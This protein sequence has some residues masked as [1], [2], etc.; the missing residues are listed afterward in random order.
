MAAVVLVVAGVYACVCTSVWRSRYVISVSRTQALWWG[1]ACQELVWKVISRGLRSRVERRDR[2][3]ERKVIKDTLLSSWLLHWVV[4]L[5]SPDAQEDG[6]ELALGLSYLRTLLIH[7]PL[8]APWVAESTPSCLLHPAWVGCRAVILQ[9][10]F[11]VL[12]H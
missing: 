6:V 7:R 9:Y 11:V 10:I 12:G 1:F 4:A 8:W 5:K 3:A 2:K